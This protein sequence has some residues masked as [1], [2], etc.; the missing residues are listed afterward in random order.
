MWQQMEILFLGTGEETAWK[1]CRS[2]RPNGYL[3]C[4]SMDWQR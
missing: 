1:F 4:S 3:E 2:Q